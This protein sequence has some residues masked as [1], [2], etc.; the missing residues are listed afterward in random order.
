MTERRIFLS[1]AHD[2]VPFVEAVAA[3]LRALG[4][5]AWFDTQSFQPGDEF[6][7]RLLDSLRSS[8]LLVV[9]IGKSVGS[10]WLNFEV[11]AALGQSK[12][13]LPVFLSHSG[14]DS[15]PAVIKR[16]PGIEA[17]DL[18]PEQVAKSITDAIPELA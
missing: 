2:D 12:A 11:G 14:R 7:T 4:V 16:L 18:T 13:V 8:S 3:A 6:S 10:P 1:Y 17:F 9:F 5:D 15:A